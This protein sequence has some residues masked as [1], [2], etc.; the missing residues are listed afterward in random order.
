VWGCLAKVALPSLKRTNIGPKTFDAVFIGYAQNSAAYRFM[1]L[2]DYVISDHRDAEF[3]EHVFPLKRGVTDVTS[4]NP[5]ISVK[6]SDPN[7][8]DR[9]LE[10]EPRRSKRRRVEINFGPDFITAFLIESFNS[11]GV[12]V[13]TEEFVSNFLIEEDPKTYQEAIKSIDATF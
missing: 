8:N 3:F 13:I 9:V 12:D 6:L 10:T 7:S 4:I 1:S 11:S 5:S 2:N